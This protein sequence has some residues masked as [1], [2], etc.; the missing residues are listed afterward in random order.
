MARF[1][2]NIYG[3]N[4]EIVKSFEADRVRWGL[5]VKAAS[6]SDSLKGRPAEE[7]IGAVGEFVRSVFPGMTEADL[8]NAD[9]GDIIAVYRQVLTSLNGI[10]GGEAKNG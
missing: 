10:K 9:I 2:L 4:D 3:G 8:E 7:A 5:I 1:S 6:L